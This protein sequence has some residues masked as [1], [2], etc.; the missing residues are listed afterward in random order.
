M[1]I[2]L[3]QRPSRRTNWIPPPDISLIKRRGSTIQ[4]EWYWMVKTKS[5]AADLKKIIL[6]LNP[7]SQ[8]KIRFR[9]L[10]YTKHLNA[11][12]G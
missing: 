6:S 10:K 7:G 5:Y 9:L 8:P 3:T 1:W 11:S 12:L 2:L 4:D